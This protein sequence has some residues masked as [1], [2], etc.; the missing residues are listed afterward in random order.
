MQS[1]SHLA[2]SAL[3]MPAPTKQ[4]T[5]W[6]G[7]AASSDQVGAYRSQKC[8]RRSLTVHVCRPVPLAALARLCGT[9]RVCQNSPQQHAALRTGPFPASTVLAHASLPEHGSPMDTSSHRPVDV[10]AIPCRG[11]SAVAICHIRSHLTPD[12][13]NIPRPL[14]AVARLPH[15]GGARVCMA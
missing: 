10:L 2:M 4:Y 11:I 5:A 15:L 14:L 7:E 13:L 3:A 9:V 1:A 12:D 8:Q 6:L